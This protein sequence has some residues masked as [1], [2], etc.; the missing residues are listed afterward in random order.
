MWYMEFTKVIMQFPLMFNLTGRHFRAGEKLKCGH[1]KNKR[2]QSNNACTMIT[3]K[4]RDFEYQNLQKEEPEFHFT[5]CT[6]RN[7]G[8]GNKDF[9]Y[10][11]AAWNNSIQ[12]LR[13][14]LR[15]IFCKN[16]K[17]KKRRNITSWA[18]KQPSEL[19]EGH[20]SRCLQGKIDF[21]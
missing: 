11:R 6:C 2:N 17:V 1:A 12:D 4:F 10:A 16:C 7:G 15:R 8:K 19:F 3:C 18:H 13:M 21:Q 14:F 20:T 9:C 5:A